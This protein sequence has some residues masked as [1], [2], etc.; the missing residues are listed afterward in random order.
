MSSVL[1]D[2]TRLPLRV[3]LG[4]GL[5]ALAWL[6]LAE[7]SAT[8]M[9]ATPWNGVLVA[10]VALPSL[11]LLL[12]LGVSSGTMNQPALA[13]LLTAGLAGLGPTL[14]ALASPYRAPSLLSA[15][16][17]LSAICLFLLVYDW[18]LTDEARR[19]AQLGR[20]LAVGAGL[21]ALVSAL[22]WVRDVAERLAAGR[23]VA[24]LFETRNPHPLGHSNYTAG[25]MLLGL[26]WLALLAWRERGWARTAATMGGLLSLLNLFACGS[27][28]GLLGLAALAVA[29]VAMA[30]IGWKRF[31]L[32]AGLAV[33]LAGLLAVANPRVRALLGPADPAAAPNASAVQRRAMFDAAVRMG[34]DRPF[35]GWGPGTTPLAY[36][37][38]RQSLDGGA[39][40]VLQ[41]H[42]T[43]LHVWAENGVLG[44]L[45]AGLF[46]GL[47][48]LS[49]RRSPPAAATLAGYGVLALTDFQ[50][51][52]PVIAAAIAVLG[53]LLA[54]PAP[55]VAGR[56][57]R[58]G[59]SVGVA[60]AAGAILVLGG[61]D[62]APALNVEALRL[63]RDPAQHARAVALLNES[64]AL[65]PDQEIAHF[66]LAWLL[67][68][69]EPAKA[70]A[71][72]RAAARLVPD[73]GGVYF[74]L[75]LARLN[76]G[77]RTGAARALALECINEP[78]FLASPWWTVPEIG[79]LRDASSRHFAH[80]I[81][82]ILPQLHQIKATWSEKHAAALLTLAP[83]FGEV[84]AGPETSY[85]RTRLGYPV[86][87]RNADLAPPIDL[88]D[89]RENPR[90]AAALPFPLPPKGWL[91][92][93]L[94][95]KLLDEAVPVRQ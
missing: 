76:Q 14:S 32:A 73:K 13:W 86:L 52:V 4:A 7:S 27:R 47:V 48:A 80:L 1:Q 8:R 30:R 24:S 69:P 46:T 15:G 70:E 65:N 78:L 40:N 42:N 37:R 64:L 95:L 90:F 83:R 36:P 72:F 10:I 79:T 25:L 26:P 43:P 6:T 5:A 84:S 34:A 82:Q 17:P 60:L 59:V 53:A 81:A 62:P 38:Y 45:A 35:L 50:L 93:P 23:T 58:L 67:V 33:V 31:L 20:W 92:S 44:L 89:V 75:G 41:L 11:G 71:H 18:V 12:R 74:G 9:F 68:V 3:M 2:P 28:G 87:M 51:D 61:R 16:L 49:W 22:Y 56:S 29:G 66:N 77:D 85:R 19:R 39:E 63:A 94:L 21:V 88:Y 91:P 54:R 55:A 57:L